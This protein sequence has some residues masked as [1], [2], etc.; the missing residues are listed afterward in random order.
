M[1][2][3]LF[4]WFWSELQISMAVD[5][6][7]HCYVIL[8]CTTSAFAHPSLTAQRI[9]YGLLRLSNRIGSW[10]D[11]VAQKFSEPTEN[12]ESMLNLLLN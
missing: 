12:V 3:E 6:S 11:F 1:A 4:K 2:A 9:Q 8:I 10:F 7:I 5:N